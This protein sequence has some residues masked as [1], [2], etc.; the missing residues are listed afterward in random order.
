M[1][2]P[3]FTTVRLHAVLPMINRGAKLTLRSGNED[4]PTNEEM[5]NI[6]VLPKDKDVDPGLLDGHDKTSTIDLLPKRISEHTSST[7]TVGCMLVKVCPHSPTSS[8][9]DC[10][11]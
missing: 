11:R 4:L 1:L 2:P 7:L 10:E 6:P 9:K 5:E 8:E 3:S